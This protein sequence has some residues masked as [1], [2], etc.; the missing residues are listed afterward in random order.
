MIGKGIFAA[1]LLAGGLYMGGA[2]GGGGW[3]REVG[4]P[5]ADV[6]GALETLDVRDQ[7]GSPGTD[8][9]RSGGVMPVFRMTH[10]A[11]QMRW[12]VMAG[13]KVAT[14]M[15]ADLTPT[16]TGTHL[17]AHVE[18]GDAPDDVTSPAFRSNGLTLA[19]FSMAIEGKLNALTRP[20]AGDAADCAKLD[21]QFRDSNLAAGADRRPANLTQAMGGTAATIMRL[22]AYGAERDRLG[23]TPAH[24]G[25]FQP[26]EEHVLP[27]EDGGS[28][29]SGRVGTSGNPRFKP[30]EPMMDATPPSGR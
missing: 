1:G 19:L 24:D 17:T 23:C 20:L 26:V 2:F 5:P 14:T 8:P 10:T 16:S 13:D 7:P 11:N 18:R 15:I 3:S 29:G 21:D 22:N 28:F 27:A 12:S 30:G 25:A 4:R 6:M 9:S